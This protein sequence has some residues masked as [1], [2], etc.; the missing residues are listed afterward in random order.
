MKKRKIKVKP[1]ALSIFKIL[2]VILCILLGLFLF[3]LKEINDLTKLGYSNKASNNILFSFKKDYVTKIGSN[4]TINRAF[5]DKDNYIEDNLDNYRKVKY[6][7]HK[8]LI[9]NINNALKKGYKTNDIN[10]IFSHGDNDSVKRFL[11]RDKV[12][13]LEEFFTVDYAKL[14]NYDRYLKYADDTGEDEETTVLYI[15]LDMDKED[16]TEAKLVDKFSID[17]LV[18]KHRNLSDKFEPTDL[19]TIP[20]EY[21]SEPD[22]QSSRIAFN[23]YKEMS[24]AATKEGYGIVINS[25]YRSYSDQEELANYYLKWYG[26]SYVDKYVAKPGFSEHQ[27]GLA[28]DIGST[29][30]NTFANSKEYTWMK[31]NAY[32]YGFIERFTKR[33]EPI[34][35]FRMEPWHYRYVGKDIAKYIHEHNIS[36][37][38]YYIL[39][40]DK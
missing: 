35:G 14:D 37:E 28:Y 9:T 34:T 13:Y 4:K 7:N 1:K 12:K 39:F 19:M 23:A 32:K 30:V 33:W 26:Q 31:E 27:T 17:M 2:G 20:S 38:E 11:K 3:Y 22:L 15:N 29:T 24:D 16:Y 25:A 5:E 10:I 36:Y 6:V 40:L 21:A 18:N 8:D